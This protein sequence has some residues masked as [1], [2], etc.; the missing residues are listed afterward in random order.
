MNKSQLKRR[1]RERHIATLAK[2]YN[3]NGAQAEELFNSLRRLECKLHRLMETACNR[4][5]TSKEEKDLERLKQRATLLTAV[6]ASPHTPLPGLMFNT[7]PRGYCIK[8]KT[9]QAAALRSIGVNIHT[10]WGGYG[11]LAPEF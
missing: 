7:D 4:E 10:D 11:I 1:D 8:I 5:L 2:M 6:S 3:L 9:E